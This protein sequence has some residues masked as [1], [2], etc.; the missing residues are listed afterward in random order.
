MTRSLRAAAV[1]AVASTSSEARSG[2][3]VTATVRS[4]RQASFAMRGYV[5]GD[6]AGTRHRRLQQGD[7][8]GLARRHRDED[9]GSPVRL[10]QLVGGATNG[11]DHP[12]QPQPQ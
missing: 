4:S 7:A 12:G 6:H 1:V 8:E 9:V 11:A 3:S 10:D 2:I 5:A